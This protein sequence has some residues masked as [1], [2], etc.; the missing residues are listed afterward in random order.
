MS[1]KDLSTGQKA[2]QMG[3]NSLKTDRNLL[4][5]G[6]KLTQMVMKLLEIGK[7]KGSQNG[8]RVDLNS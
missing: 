3:I 1:K 4:Q 6:R 2:H 8:K 7:K 5:M